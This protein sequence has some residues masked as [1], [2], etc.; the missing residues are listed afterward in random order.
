[1]ESH[2]KE[3]S[4][5][6]S[7]LHKTSL[8]LAIVSLVLLTPFSINNFIQGRVLLGVGSAVIVLVLSFTAWSNIRYGHYYPLILLLFFAP[9]IIFFLFFSISTQGLI[10]VFWCYPAIIGFYF[11]LPERKAWLSNTALLL[12]VLPKIFSVVEAPMALRILMTLLGVSG[13]AAIFVRVIT[14]QQIELQ[15]QTIIDPLTE[16]FNRKPLQEILEQAVLQNFRTKVP[17]SLAAVDLDFFKSIND[18]FGHDAGDIV[19]REVGKIL[20]KRCRRVDKVFRLGG[21]EFLVLLYGTNLSSAKFVAEELRE[22]IA[23]HS[24]LDEQKVTASIGVAELVRG[25]E[26]TEWM[27]R[28]DEKLY[29][30]KTE[31][32]NRVIS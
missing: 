5:S 22:I 16:V 31:G 2:A 20:R 14:N 6:T 32:R 26:W 27:K 7:F 18:E 12:V 24:F 9:A 19:L 10:G 13:F 25:E 1:M 23:A 29:Q 28:S 30:A 11:M 3:Y 4:Q 15:K 17:M 8:G 21:E